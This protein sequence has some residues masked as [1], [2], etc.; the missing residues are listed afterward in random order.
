M[1]LSTASLYSP[2]LWA[3]RCQLPFA[4]VSECVAL[5]N[6]ARSVDSWESFSSVWAGW[7]TP[8]CGLAAY[9]SALGQTSQLACRHSECREVAGKQGSRRNISGLKRSMEGKDSGTR[10]QRL[11]MGWD[12]HS[13]QWKWKKK[14]TAYLEWRQKTEDTSWNC[15]HICSALG[16]HLWSL[17]FF[18]KT[19]EQPGDIHLIIRC[20]LL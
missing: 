14:K 20:F 4:T 17:V 1:K 12:G 2:S 11:Q 3:Q 10:L 15:K 18:E 8:C 9:D 5:C 7:R 19:D 13:E 16:N 6:S